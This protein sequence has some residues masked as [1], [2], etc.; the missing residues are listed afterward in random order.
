MSCPIHSSPWQ[1]DTHANFHP[2]GMG[3]LIVLCTS[4]NEPHTS[5]HHIANFPNELPSH[6]ISV[7]LTTPPQFH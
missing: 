4:E 6:I 2:L 5:S 1:L 7:L 3:V